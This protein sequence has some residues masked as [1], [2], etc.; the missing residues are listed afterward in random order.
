[1]AGCWLPGGPKPDVQDEVAVR[2]AEWV[3]GLLRLG[4]VGDP[5]PCYEDASSFCCFY[6]ELDDA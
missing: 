4:F 5:R 1:M 3:D 2:K 6:F